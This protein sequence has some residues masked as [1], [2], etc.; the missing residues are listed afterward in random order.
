MNEQSL[1]LWVSM[2]VIRNIV[3]I[4]SANRPEV[5]NNICKQAALA[6]ADLERSD[7]KISLDQNCAI[8]SAALSLSED[9][10]LGLHVGEKTAPSVLGLVGHLLESSKDALSA[11]QHVQDFTAA[12]TKLYTFHITCQDDKVFYFCEPITIW[13]EVSPET[14]R[15]SVDICFAAAMHILK[16]ITGQTLKLISAQYRYPVVTD[17]AEHERILGCKPEFNQPA[18]CIVFSKIDLLRPIIGY[19]KTIND[20]L[21]QL[22]KQELVNDKKSLTFSSLV[23]QTIL[24]NFQFGFP[25]LETLADLLNLTPRTLQRKLHKQETNYRT[26]EEAV[27]HEVANLLLKNDSISFEEIAFKL[28]YA[29]QSS[30]NRAFRQ[31]TGTTPAR[32]RDSNG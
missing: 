11:L 7:L 6:E 17:T 15:H 4:A 25:Q 5:L 24:N 31:W 22:V 26:V 3:I 20:T 2:P 28:G 9:T 8:M 10:C 12:F 29:D 16:L 21:S 14:A 19:N 27:K 23:K 18:N 30:F 13:N 1:T 32:Y